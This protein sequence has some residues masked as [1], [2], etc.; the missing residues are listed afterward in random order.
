MAQIELPY[1]YLITA[2]AVATN[3]QMNVLEE[4]TPM[5]HADCK[6]L[7]EFDKKKKQICDHLLDGIC[8]DKKLWYYDKIP[9][10]LATPESAKEKKQIRDRLTKVYKKLRKALYHASTEDPIDGDII[11]LKNMYEEDGI[12]DEPPANPYFSDHCFKLPMRMVVFAPSGTVCDLFCLFIIDVIL[13]TGEKQ[14]CC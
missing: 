10:G 12:I 9:N 11:P 3:T 1:G 6:T 14:L 2:Y 13:C 8:P 5:V 4:M 7:S